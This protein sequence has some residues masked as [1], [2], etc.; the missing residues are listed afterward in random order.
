MIRPAYGL[1]AYVVHGIQYIMSFADPVRTKNVVINLS[2][3]PTTGPH[4]DTAEL[5]A[6]LTALVAEFDGSP[7]TPKLEIV[8]AAGNAY[9]SEGHVVFKRDT[10]Q[11]DQVEWTW[12]LPPD[13][14]VLCFAEVWMKTADVRRA[15]S[16]T[17][18]SPSGVIYKRTPPIPAPSPLP[19]AG[20]T[21]RLSGATT[22]C[23]GFKSNPPSL[24]GIE[25]PPNM[26]NTRSR[27]PVFARKRRF[28]P[29]WHAVILTWTRAQ[30]PSFRILSTPSGS[31]LGR[32]RPVAI[33][34]MGSSIRQGRW[35][36]A[37]EPSMGSRPPRTRACM[38][39]VATLFRM[40]ASRA[41]H[42]R[43]LRVT[44][45]SRSASARTSY[46]P[47]T[48]PALSRAYGRQATGA[49]PYFA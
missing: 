49:A 45:R 17:L 1:R 22:R 8:L 3:G 19:P 2:Y 14:S 31:E 13:N 18:T 15:T 4:D 28:M 16:V 48:S 12:R 44:G 36:I 43:V 7:G 26:G 23:G 10:T 32:L 21:A 6:A 41:I 34:P 5:E 47:A 39:P 27:S 25:L 42:R 38:L 37:T 9:L 40:D 24:R 20:W 29:M 30:A 46:F 11:P 33:T 35:S